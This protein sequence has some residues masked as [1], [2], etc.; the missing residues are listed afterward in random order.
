MVGPVVVRVR[1]HRTSCGPGPADR[2]RR[3]R[4]RVATDV[5]VQ[6][7]G[8]R[9][10]NRNRK[11]SQPRH[12]AQDRLAGSPGARGSKN[13]IYWGESQVVSDFHCHL[14][15]PCRQNCAPA[16]HALALSSQ[17]SAAWVHLVAPSV[18][19]TD[20]TVGRCQA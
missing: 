8:L 20:G 1:P 4:L 12:L 16:D 19:P 14:I 9:V 6:Q 2:R 13:N 5:A 3:V 18:S 10:S 17:C 15:F 7:T 11:S